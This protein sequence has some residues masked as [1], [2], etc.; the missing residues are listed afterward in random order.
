M[1]RLVILFAALF[2]FTAPQA[3]AA[4]SSAKVSVERGG[5]FGTQAVGSTTSKTVTVTNTGTT[6]VYVGTVSVTSHDGA[7][8][9]DFSSNTCGGSLEPGESCSFDVLFTP[10]SPG[11]LSG[12]TDVGIDNESTIIRLRG[13]GV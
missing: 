10:P 7:F 1:R 2:L 12:W 6:V 9:L 13:R 4:P 5:N 8:F 11:T 3:A